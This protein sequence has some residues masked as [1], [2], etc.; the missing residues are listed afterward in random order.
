MLRSL[1]SAAVLVSV[2]H[3]VDNTVRWDDFIPADPDDLTLSFIERW[4][5]P[6][7]W[8][9]FTACAFAGYRAF[10]RRRWPQAAAWLGAYSGSGLVGIGHY[11]DIPP[12]QLTAFQNAHVMVDIV[13]GALVLGFAVWIVLRMPELSDRARSPQ[14]GPRTVDPRRRPG[15]FRRLFAA[16]GA[17][18]VWLFVSRHV[19][20]YVDPW[21]LRL[22]NGRL[23]S[24]LV[25]PTGLLETR[26]ARTGAVR[27]KAVIYFHDLERDPQR[28]IVAASNAGRPDNPSWY[29]N[30]V[31]H[32]D[33]R[34][35]GVP[36][37]ATVIDDS[38][39]DRL[40][41]LADNV[42]PAF[43]RYRRTAAAAGRKIPLVE[44]TAA[45]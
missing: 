23:A 26:G 42:F 24:P 10:R 7:A 36:M 38:E 39:H 30:L 1:L 14:R 19:N 12:S 31:A 16:V 25:F 45:S 21:L 34:F 11:L 43:A 33:V 20:W 32:P 35:V 28:V 15:W 41:R 40:W 29:Y 44:L 6:V 5:I 22:S 4:T 3:Y 27:R 17:T 37:K 18:R 13:L 8:V 9:A 2:V